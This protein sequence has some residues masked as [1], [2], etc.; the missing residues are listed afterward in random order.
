MKIHLSRAMSLCL[1]LFL[2]IFALA[3][4]ASAG[5]IYA[6]NDNAAGNMIYG[7]SVNET[8][9]ELTPLAGFP[10]ATG[11]NGGGSTNLEMIAIDKLNARMYVINRG[12]NNISAYSINTADGSISPLPFS[13]ITGV[14]EQR[15]LEIHPSGSPLIVA[16]DVFSSYNITETAATPAEGSPYAMPEGVSPTASTL[17]QDGNFYYAGGNTGNFFAGF[18][19]NAKT[20]VLTPIKGSPYDSGSSTPNPTATDAAGR[21]YV[22]NS[23]QAFVRVYT[24]AFGIPFPVTG[25]PF[26]GTQTGFAA[27]GKVHPNGGFLAVSNRTRNHVAVLAITGS[28]SDT[29]LT[30]VKGSPFA[31]GGTSSL[32][33]AFNADGSLF[34]SGNGASRNITSFKV[35]GTTGIF[36]DQIVGEVNSLGTAGSLAGME[37]VSFDAPGEAVSVAGRV[38]DT[39]TAG[40][41]RALVTFTDEGGTSVTAVTNTFG[42]YKVDGLMTGRTYTVTITQRRN[43]ILTEPL[44]LKGELSD[45]NFTIPLN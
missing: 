13:P 12:S 9:G 18:A 8:T 42:N 14:A 28:G 15:A 7:F 20:G 25:S 11:F 38:M 27:Q 16:S 1:T 3:G 5:F 43:V 31:T 23:R 4:S 44:E 41:P 24:L 33:N 45:L 36:S 34:F 2:S 26:G 37:Y 22:I 21:L 39:N 35:D 17:T 32:I 29:V 10:V 6:V 19:V 30:P 40:A